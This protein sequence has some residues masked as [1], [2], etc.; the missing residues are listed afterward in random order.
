[1]TDIAVDFGPV[2][3]LQYNASGPLDDVYVVT[4]GGLG[5]VGLFAVEQN[6]N[7]ITFIFNQP[8]CAGTTPGHGATSFFFGLASDKAPHAVNAKVSVPGFEALDVPARAPA[9]GRPPLVL[10]PIIVPLQPRP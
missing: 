3:K 8:V 10:H 2:T 4:A 7:V 6:G 5:S 1:V 9:H